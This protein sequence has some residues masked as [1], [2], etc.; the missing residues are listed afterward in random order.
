MQ[1]IIQVTK[2]YKDS[3]LR[4][5]CIESCSL[6]YWINN[7]NWNY[8]QLAILRSKK[9]IS[10]NVSKTLLSKTQ[11]LLQHGC[12][13]SMHL[14]HCFLKQSRVAVATWMLLK[15]VAI[16]VILHIFCYTSLWR[17]YDCKGRRA[18]RTEYKIS[19]LVQVLYEKK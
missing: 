12:Y 14:K 4:I 10:E 1:Y 7:L 3:F 17:Q 15:E 6:T 19:L 2:N 5:N 16:L 18:I 8:R 9:W 13:L 11:Y